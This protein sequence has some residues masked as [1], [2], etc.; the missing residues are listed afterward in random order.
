MNKMRMQLLDT[1]WLLMESADTPMH[2][3]V[4]ATFKMPRSAPDN[5]LSLM[6][7]QMRDTGEVIAPWNYRLSEKVAASVGPQLIEDVGFDLNYHFRHSALPLP[8]GERELG[9]IVSRLHSQPLDRA[10]PLWE[11]HLIEGL[12]HNRF[13]FYFKV[14][15]ALIDNVNAIPMLLVGLSA[16][17]AKKN[18]LPLW[19]KPLRAGGEEGGSIDDD[20]FASP[21]KFISSIG[22]ATSGFIRSSFDRQSRQSL[23]TLRGTP[24]STLNRHINSQRRFATQQFELKYIEGLA[25]SSNSS[26]NEILAY[27]CASSLRRFFKEYNT[28]P[29]EPLIAALP[30]SLQERSEHLPGNAIAGIRVALATDIG[31]P[32][33]RL[34]AIKATMKAVRDDRASLPS[35]AVTSYVLMRAAPVYASQIPG[36]GRLVPPPFNLVVSNTPGPTRAQ[37]FNGARMEAIYPL[38]SLMQFS[39]LSIDCAGYAGTLNIGFTGARDTLPHLQRLA[40]YMGRAADDLEKLLQVRE[41]AS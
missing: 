37:Y 19:A 4:L 23:L 20:F 12:E 14:H 39:A 28:L 33:A 10:R 35:E 5:Y 32:L 9:V 31:D 30:V 26:V 25:N 1:V 15:R 36:L 41:Q 40:I 29:D 22:K 7:Q 11:F 21:L 18:M 8:G 13:A 34:D 6:A 38:S 27:L 17:A 24:R 3:G 2:V 16:S